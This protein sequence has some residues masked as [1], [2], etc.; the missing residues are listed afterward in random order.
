[1]G[2]VIALLASKCYDATNVKRNINKLWCVAIASVIAVPCGE[3]LGNIIMVLANEETAA[4]LPQFLSYYTNNFGRFL[5]DS[6]NSLLL[7]YV[8]AA[9][10]GVK[11]FKDI[12]DEDKRLEKMEE[13]LEAMEET[14]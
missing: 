9:I 10:G 7:G 14:E 5:L 8:F 4:Y 12:K 13:E 1:M 2:F 3:F 6:A 11:V